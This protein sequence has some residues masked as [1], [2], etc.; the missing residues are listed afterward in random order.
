MENIPY[1]FWDIEGEQHG[2][3]YTLARH[4]NLDEHTDTTTAFKRGMAKQI[5]LLNHSLTTGTEECAQAYTFA[6]YG[7]LEGYEDIA[8]AFKAGMLK[9]LEILSVTKAL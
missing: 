4:G 6:E 8:E 1:K 2:Q 3:A 9:Q 5:V 7:E